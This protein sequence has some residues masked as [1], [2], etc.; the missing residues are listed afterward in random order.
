MAASVG[1]ANYYIELNSYVIGYI[2]SDINNFIVSSLFSFEKPEVLANLAMSVR[3]DTLT[4]LISK[5]PTLAKFISEK[6]SFFLS[7]FH[8]ALIYQRRRII[9]PFRHFDLAEL[10]SRL[11]MLEE[12]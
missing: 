5:F 7:C 4:M 8:L 3:T 2:I 9:V 11:K 6:V 10:G 1:F 12:K